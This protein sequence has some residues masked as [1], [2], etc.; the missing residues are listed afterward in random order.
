MIVYIIEPCTDGSDVLGVSFLEK[1][2]IYR[3]FVCEKCEIL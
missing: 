3:I 1:C 2:E